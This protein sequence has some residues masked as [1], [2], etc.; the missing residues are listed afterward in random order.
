LKL[1]ED[2]REPP[3]AYHQQPEIPEW[4]QFYWSAFNELSSERQISMGVGPI[5][6]S[7]IRDYAVE[8][9]LSGDMSDKFM[10]IIHGLDV[11][12]V[13]MA[14]KPKKPGRL[15]DVDEVSVADVTGAKEVLGR[16]VARSKG[17][18]RGKSGRNSHSDAAGEG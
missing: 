1:I 2:G 3:P 8:Y 13:E 17:K 18:T 11:E 7:A 4:Y 6:R 12:Y 9:E 14:N 10:R 5:P 15:D 16:L